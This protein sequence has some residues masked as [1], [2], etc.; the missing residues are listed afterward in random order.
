MSQRLLSICCSLFILLA[1]LLP[2][3]LVAQ[4][5]HAQVRLTLTGRI[6]FR[7]KVKTVSEGEIVAVDDAGVEQTFQIQGKDERGVSVADGKAF[8]QAPAKVTVT[9]EMKAADLK[10]GAVLRF[11]ANV[12][13]LGATDG[14]I[15]EMELVTGDDAKPGLVTTADVAG[16][17][18]APCTVTGTFNRLT[19]N[20]MLIAVPRSELT[21]KTA[22]AFKLSKECKVNISSDDY[23]RA[24]RDDEI[25]RLTGMK[26]STG[27]QVI[28][29]LRIKL[30]ADSAAEAGSEGGVSARYLKLS[31]EP[32]KPR[33][34]RSR[35][36]LVHTDISDRQAQMLL[37]KLETMVNLV[38]RYF[39]RNPSRPVEC[40]VVRDLKQWPNGLFDSMQ[41]QKIARNEGVTLHRG[42]QA[43]VYSCDDHNVVQPEAI[44]AFCADT[45]GSTGPTWYS[46]G[47]AELGA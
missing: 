4:H 13:R 46:E 15:E 30:A 26:F 37:D 35:N 45:F 2:P 3:A 34:V 22:L 12:S 40:Y 47:F 18:F 17:K 16:K 42:R 27:D 7:G 33:D 25:V 28:R 43:V 41:M 38:S 29:E 5:A 23:R 20:R 14:E 19:G 44:H 8:I 36:F 1:L 24:G 11:Q 6:D 21:R 9:G 39:G 10:R 31:D 32:K